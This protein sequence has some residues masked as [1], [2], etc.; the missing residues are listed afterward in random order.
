[1]CVL[2]YNFA[3]YAIC[4]MRLERLVEV[5]NSLLIKIILPPRNNVGIR[6]IFIE[7]EKFFNA[8]GSCSLNTYGSPIYELMSTTCDFGMEGFI[9][10]VIESGLCML[11]V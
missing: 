7:Y 11:W 5:R 10:N 8:T 1:M 6:N 9:R 2:S 4:R 3:F